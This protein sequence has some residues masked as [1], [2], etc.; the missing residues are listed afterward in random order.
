MQLAYL[1]GIE[2]SNKFA[3]KYEIG[4]R[5]VGTPHIKRLCAA[6]RTFSIHTKGVCQI[7]T[8]IRNGAE[9]RKTTD[10]DIITMESITPNGISVCQARQKKCHYYKNIVKRHLNDI[11]E[12]IKSSK[13][14]MEKNFYKGR[15]AVQL[16][17]YARALNVQEKYLERFI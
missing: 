17:A 2:R 6:S 9:C 4:S 13:N 8:F 5:A 15:Y 12:N 1:F 3:Y 7:Q 11:K 10:E 16:N 14:G